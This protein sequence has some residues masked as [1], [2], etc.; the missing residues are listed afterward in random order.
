MPTS[1][2]DIFGGGTVQPSQVSYQQYILTEDITLVWPTS[3]VDSPFVT[4][5]II[6]VEPTLEDLTL[7]FPDATEISVGYDLILNNVG[8]N[9][10]TVNNNEGSLIFTSGMG[11]LTYL[12]LIDNTT[13]GGTWRVS[14]FA[15]GSSAVTQ[16]AATTSTPGFTITG[17]PITS[18][19][20]L[21]FELSLLTLWNAQTANTL[22]GAAILANSLPGDSIADNTQSLSKLVSG[23]N[24]SFVTGSSASTSF[25]ELVYNP[26]NSQVWYLPTQAGAGLTPSLQSLQTIW[27]AQTPNT[28]TGAQLLAN[29]T[30]VTVIP[31]S[32]EFLPLCMGY[33]A[34]NGTLLRSR[35]VGTFALIATGQYQITFLTPAASNAYIVLAQSDYGNTAPPTNATITATVGNRTN[36]GFQIFTQTAATGA[37]VNSN[38]NFIVLD[39]S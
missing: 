27:N 14:P 3:F 24:N 6:D 25:S 7:T 33:A 30:P 35:R 29:S 31:N 28:F 9:D 12:Y 34:A 10:L 16:V 36:S 37:S 19:G 23:R 1:Y 11:S 8:E 13:T 18:S 32:N 4:A 2:T 22:T 5:R 26:N 15:G 17:S 20:T 21:D 38:F 39:I